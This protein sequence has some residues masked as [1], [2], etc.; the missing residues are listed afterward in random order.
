MTHQDRDEDNRRPGLIVG[1]ENSTPRIIKAEA[2]LLRLPLFALNTKGLRTLDAIECRGKLNRDDT[3][4][5]FVFRASRSATM[6][7]PGP[8]ARSAH[9]A[10]LS[11]ATEQGF[12]LQ[13]PIA[14]G[15]RD[16][17]RRMGISPSGRTV[18]RLK[19]AIA[20]TAALSITSVYALYSKPAGKRIRTREEVL[21]LYER[22]CFL[23][24]EL[25]EG[26]TADTNLVWFADW[27]LDNLNAFFT[28]PLDYELWLH[29]DQRSPI[30][31]RLYEF[32]L[33][34][35][36]SGVPVLRINYPKLTQFLPVRTERHPSQSRQQLGPALALLTDM[37]V[38]EETTWATSREG[39]VQLH[40]HRGRRLD[41]PGYKGS[42]AFTPADEEFTDA[43]EIEEL[44]TPRPPEWAIV[45]DF[46]RMWS[47]Q[48]DHKPTRKELVQARELIDQ[49]GPIKAR[50]LIQLVV[51]RLKKKWPDAKT[52]GSVTKYLG[53]VAEEY[54]ADQRRIE[55][56]RQEQARRLKEREDEER[57]RVERERFE[58]EWR[59]VWDRLSEPDREVIRRAVIGDNPLLARMPTMVEG[60][61]MEELARR[62]DVHGTGMPD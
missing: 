18:K 53:E 50:A 6:P 9:L 47:R 2:N 5:E 33:L 41:Q 26:G 34:N 30:A 1:A 62:Q 7:Y 39:L 12:P 35:F 48:E 21:H 46:Y 51:K 40:F 44:R 16:L 37:K 23:G 17:C 59:P 56:E 15:W 20:S 27:Y 14:W 25:P 29:L 3:A 43:V 45:S 38:I 28:A 49:H 61:C 22:V 36:Y 24:S 4:H 8:L 31:S 60:L 13:N 42:L 32:L 55:H 19:A 54:D 52:F 10:F 57:R 11:R 58:A